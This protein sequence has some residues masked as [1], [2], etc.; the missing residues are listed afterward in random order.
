MVNK[1]TKRLRR[2]IEQDFLTKNLTFV[3]AG[4]NAYPALATGLGR[5]A[6]GYLAEVYGVWQGKVQTVHVL[7]T[8]QYRD[9]EIDALARVYGCRFLLHWRAEQRAAYLVNLDLALPADHYN[10]FAFA[11][12]VLDGVRWLN[13][14]Q[15]SPA[16]NYTRFFGQALQFYATTD[17]VDYDEDDNGDDNG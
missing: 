9:E 15:I 3:S 11:V 1:V 14:W 4:N 5:P 16:D 2:G 12:K 6:K 17:E 7:D 8:D 13:D 10:R